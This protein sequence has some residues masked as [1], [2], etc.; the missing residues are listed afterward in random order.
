MRKVFIAFIL[1]ILP[2]Y[3]FCFQ[4][5]QVGPGAIM[6][7]AEDA[8]LKVSSEWSMTVSTTKTDVV[9]PIAKL[10]SENKKQLYYTE[11]DMN[12]W[13]ILSCDKEKRVIEHYSPK[14]F[15]SKYFGDMLGINHYPLWGG[16]AHVPRENERE[17][18][19]AA[20][21]MLARTP[22]KEVKWYHSVPEWVKEIQ[23]RGIGVFGGAVYGD[24]MNSYGLWYYPTGGEYDLSKLKSPEEY[25]TKELI[26]AY[27]N[28]K[29]INPKNTVTAPM[30]CA[31]NVSFEWLEEFYKLNPNKY[32][33]VFDI[34]PY[35]KTS[36]GHE[37]P[38]GVPRGAPE[39]LISD[40]KIL[41]G[42]MKKYGDENKP[43][44]C[45]EYG[46]SSTPY[47]NGGGDLSPKKQ[48]EYLMR[49]LILLN[50]MDIKR[51]YLY[52]FFDEGQNVYYTEHFYGMVDYNLQAKPAFY[53]IIEIGKQLDKAIYQNPV[54]GL[55]SPCFG[56]VF[57]DDNG[58][59]TTLWDAGG[60]SIVKVATSE[61]GLECY[62]LFGKK[63]TIKVE[64]GEAT[65][66][67]SPSLVY[68]HSKT[69]ISIKSVK[70]APAVFEEG[71]NIVFDK[72]VYITSFGN[73]IKI[74]AKL[75]NGYKNTVNGVLELVDKN[76]VIGK[77]NFVVGSNKST[78]VAID[79]N[80]KENIAS[81]DKYTLRVTYKTNLET[82]VSEK[83]I[84]I[85][86]V[87]NSDK[88]YINKVK[89]FN[90][91][92]DVYVLGNKNIEVM[93]IPAQ[94]SRICEFIDKKSLT[95][96]IVMSYDDIASLTNFE[97]ANTIWDSVNGFFRDAA[98]TAKEEV[99]PKEVKLITHTENDKLGYTK[100]I[101]VGSDTNYFDTNL[102]FENKT[103]SPQ[104]IKYRSHPEYKV[105]G[106]AD[107]NTDVVIMDTEDGNIR[108]PLWLG[109]GEKKHKA[110]KE[111]YVA[112]ED[113]TNKLVYVQEFDPKFISDVLVWF[114]PTSYNFELQGK[115][116]SVPANSA[117][118]TNIRT[119]I[120]HGSFKDFKK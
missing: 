35:S 99:S 80:S 1:L 95:N 105:G 29:K 84:W 108:M 60:E 14:P 81:L 20:L 96:Q 90:T 117:E 2:I 113:M 43:I 59:I 79:F 47:G 103:S 50:S 83:Y 18:A 109:L 45:T 66:R 73:K 54:S 69:P 23:K 53:A 110:L 67:I 72:D 44:I 5:K 32:F 21:D 58:F 118:N 62:D 7:I 104:T 102:T 76:K 51:V 88:A 57:K 106:T 115:E 10:S 70:P 61:S 48:A 74:N 3:V 28:M 33:D 85:R 94:G 71:I 116:V 75:E 39:A 98:F 91:K 77:T 16:G 55:D 19:I 101:V 38:Y 92:D 31:E 49:A 13:I 56:Y 15:E 11:P 36:G 82:L 4:V 24:T 17:W 120:F 8:D 12:L 27:E 89:V 114:G 41:K 42:I 64:N 46:Y 40:I 52:S 112:L 87:V 107:N 30:C 111:Y 22:I 65:L 25:V 6:V 68:V 100:T 37:V 9:N 119:T 86:N 63:K 34:H 78:D 97:W 93:V 26:P